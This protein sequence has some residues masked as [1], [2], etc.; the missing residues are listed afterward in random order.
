M[1]TLKIA[2]G[3][4]FVYTKPEG[5]KP[6]KRHRNDWYFADLSVNVS[7]QVLAVGED[8]NRRVKEGTIKHRNGYPIQLQKYFYFLYLT[9]SRRMEPTM[10]TLAIKLENVGGNVVARITK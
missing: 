4:G 9:G 2:V 6:I 3:D 8:Y 7:E 1:Q 10:M 5:Y